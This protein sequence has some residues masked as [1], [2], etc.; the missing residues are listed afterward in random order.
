VLFLL[1][2]DSFPPRHAF[3]LI[4][5]ALAGLRVVGSA[6]EHLFAEPSWSLRVITWTNRNRYRLTHN[7]YGDQGIFVRVATFRQLEGYQDLRLME[8]VDF[9]RRLK[10][11]GR[12]VVIREPLRTCGRRFLARGP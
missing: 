3:A 5:H 6:F 2:A 1:H 9:T 8:D 12:T 4:E 10:R 7:Y 11:V